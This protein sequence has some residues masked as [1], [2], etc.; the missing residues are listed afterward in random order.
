MI[1]F[2]DFANSIAA[3]DAS[4]YAHVQLLLK[5]PMEVRLVNVGL[6]DM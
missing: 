4:R 3:V 6:M 5:R 1:E 2:E